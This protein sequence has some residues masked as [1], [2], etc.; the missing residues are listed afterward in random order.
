MESMGQLVLKYEIWFGGWNCVCNRFWI[1]QQVYIGE[2]DLEEKETQ[3][4]LITMVDM[5]KTNKYIRL[6][7]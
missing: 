5:L 7:L 2:V 1:L 4:T 3:D 6:V